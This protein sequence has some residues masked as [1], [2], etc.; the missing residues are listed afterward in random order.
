[1]SNSYEA[2]KNDTSRNFG[3]PVMGSITRTFH[4][5]S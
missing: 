4:M 3:H 2:V 5:V 1:M